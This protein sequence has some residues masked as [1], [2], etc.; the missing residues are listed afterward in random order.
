MF[1]YFALGSVG[2]LFISRLKK[3]QSW[4][5]ICQRAQASAFIWPQMTPNI[6]KRAMKF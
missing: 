4:T 5:G 1:F 3:Q 2:F 6:D